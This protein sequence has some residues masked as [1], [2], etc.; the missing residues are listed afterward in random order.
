MAVVGADTHQT[1][2][3]LSV[4]KSDILERAV[5]L[6]EASLEVSG[7][8]ARTFDL[9]KIAALMRCARKLGPSRTRRIVTC[10]GCR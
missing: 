2:S 3:D 9:C 6:R 8:D 10:T 7:L 1:L 5:G 4:G